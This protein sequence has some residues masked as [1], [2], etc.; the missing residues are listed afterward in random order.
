MQ[1]VDSLTRSLVEKIAKTYHDMKQEGSDAKLTIDGKEVTVENPA[2]ECERT[3]MGA[4]V[5]GKQVKVQY[6]EPTT[7]GYNMQYCGGNFE[8]LLATSAEIA[9]FTAKNKDS[10]INFGCVVS[11]IAATA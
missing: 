5:N 3:I 9:T 6:F 11:P 8:V 7:E 4:K 1:K 10:P 2:F